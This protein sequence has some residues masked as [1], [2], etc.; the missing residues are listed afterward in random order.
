MSTMLHR[1][2]ELL[3]FLSS[4]ASAALEH[5]RYGLGHGWKAGKLPQR[6][7]AKVDMPAHQHASLTAAL[8]SLSESA[9]AAAR[10]TPLEDTS[11]TAKP[12]DAREPKRR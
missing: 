3:F 10:S 7:E 2:P 8:V 5:Y 6:G 12:R 9:A 11:S 1:T 4:V